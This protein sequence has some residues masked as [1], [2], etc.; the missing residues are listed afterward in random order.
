[1]GSDLRSTA[2]YRWTSEQQR[3]KYRIMQNY[4]IVRNIINTG[5]FTVPVYR[6][7]LVYT[8]G[9]CK[10]VVK[11]NV[12]AQ[13]RSSVLLYH[14]SHKLQNALITGF[15]TCWEIASWHFHKLM[16]WPEALVCSVKKFNISIF[17]MQT[18]HFTS[19]DIDLSLIYQLCHICFCFVSYTF[20]T[21]CG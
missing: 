2:I 3:M 9:K 6:A 17:I 4:D 19:E 10:H 8:W 7:S 21:V 13:W 20:W 18:Y 15:T 11:R 12:S 5:N 16:C 14:F 1:M